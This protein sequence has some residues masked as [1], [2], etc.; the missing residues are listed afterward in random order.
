MYRR[1]QKAFQFVTIPGGSMSLLKILLKLHTTC[2]R[3][4]G[5]NV[6]HEIVVIR[7][8]PTLAVIAGP[9]VLHNGL[10]YVRASDSII[11]LLIHLRT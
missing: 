11:T 6:A 9:R 8:R 1:G 7:R 4:Q 2:L 5:F 10:G 3:G